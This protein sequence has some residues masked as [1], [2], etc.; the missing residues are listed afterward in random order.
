MPNPRNPRH[1]SRVELSARN[2]DCILFLTKNPAPM[3]EQFRELEKL[4]YPF[5]VHVTLTPYGREIE[6][7]LPPKKQI[8]ESLTELTKRIGSHRVVW[9]YDPI[10][11]DHRF[12]VEWHTE[13]FSALCRELQGKVH[14]CLLS[15]VDI[16]K[17]TARSFRGMTHDE[18]RLVATGFARAAE[19]HSIGLST[20]AETIDL[21]EFGVKHGACVD[22][23][24]IEEV[25]GSHL[26][27]KGDPNRRKMCLCA[28]A[29]DIGAYNTCPH[30]CTYCYAVYGTGKAAR[31]LVEHDPAA[32]MLTGYPNGTET[33]TERTKKSYKATQFSLL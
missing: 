2:I 24:H 32:P 12:S 10:V 8:L 1:L 5:I 27:V 26:L 28:E 9:R 30:G 29:V 31:A 20:C 15:F 17:H 22:K 16:Y 11:L 3:M 13:C 14:H 7:G 19:K 25:I 21:D 6:P 18:M 33:V 4:G 23:N